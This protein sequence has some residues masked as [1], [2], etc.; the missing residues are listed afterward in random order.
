MYAVYNIPNTVPV[1][2]ICEHFNVVV[3]FSLYSIVQVAPPE[4]MVKMFE[5]NALYFVRVCLHYI[6]SMCAFAIGM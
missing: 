4:V 2:N 6:A 3:I 1:Q 5:F